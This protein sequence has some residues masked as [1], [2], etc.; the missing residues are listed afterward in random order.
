[1][2]RRIM[3]YIGTALTLIGLLTVSGGVWML[4]PP[5]ALVVLGLG[6]TLLGLMLCGKAGGMDA[7]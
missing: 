5:A 7:G 4:S 2:K 6:I 3:D 1:M